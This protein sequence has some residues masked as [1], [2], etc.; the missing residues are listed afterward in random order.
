MSDYKPSSIVASLCKK[1]NA[2]PVAE[3]IR[4]D[5][6]VVIVV[7]DGRKLVFDKD[8]ITRT[9]TEPI[10]QDDILPYYRPEGETVSKSTVH[11]ALP[12]SAANS[13]GK[14]NKKRGRHAK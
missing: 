13:D 7:E 6:T 10:R 4:L 1:L 3:A 8:G 12:V 5:G 9:L 14:P 11:A 2:V